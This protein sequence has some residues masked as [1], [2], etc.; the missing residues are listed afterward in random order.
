MGTADYCILVVLVLS[1]LVTLSILHDE[2]R[3]ADRRQHGGLPPGGL[4]RRSGRDRRGHSL[5]AYVLWAA[6]AQWTRFRKLL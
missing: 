2:Q 1:G 3:L 5:T 6:R 4:E